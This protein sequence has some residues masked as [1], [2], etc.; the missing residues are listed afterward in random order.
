MLFLAAKVTLGSKKHHYL[1]TLA[2]LCSSSDFDPLMEE[3]DG[4]DEIV[5]KPTPV[6][7]LLK[8]QVYA[9]QCFLV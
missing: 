5:S 7:H 4:K 2:K 6:K 8:Y 9:K 3:R 1:I